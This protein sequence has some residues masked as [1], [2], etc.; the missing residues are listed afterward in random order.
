M[1][2]NCRDASFIAV[3]KELSKISLLKR[4]RLR[5]HLLMCKPCRLFEEHIL[6]LS[7]KMKDISGYYE[8]HK[9]FHL[10]DAECKVRISK[11]LDNSFEISSK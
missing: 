3:Q 9:N 2:Y 8:G 4:I 1:I 10:M 6:D 7:G 5:L 11:A